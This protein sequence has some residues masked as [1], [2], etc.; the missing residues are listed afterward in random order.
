MSESAVKEGAV[1]KCS[2]GTAQSELKVP[3]NHGVESQGGNQANIA[4]CVGNVNIMSFCS[5]NRQVP[6]VPCMPIIQMKWVKGQ[7]TR[8]LDGEF[9]LLENCIVPCIYGGVI[10]ILSSGQN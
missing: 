10:R 5:C 3:N 7:K 4:D 6:P 1:L 2:L 8:V 9:T